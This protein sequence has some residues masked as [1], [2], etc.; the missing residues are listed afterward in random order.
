MAMCHSILDVSDNLEDMAGLVIIYLDEKCM[1]ITRQAC[2][3]NSI[4]IT[5]YF[6]DGLIRGIFSM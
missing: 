3:G 6:S 5:R 1:V 2:V 4:D